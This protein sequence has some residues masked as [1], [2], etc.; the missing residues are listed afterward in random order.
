ML[1][2]AVALLVA[3]GQ[4]SQA[5]TGELRV[6]VTDA[7]GG[8]LPGPVEVVSQGNEIR[9]QIDTD[10]NGLAIVRRLPFGSYRVIVSRSGFADAAQVV[11]V[12]SALPTDFHVTMNVSAVQTQTTVTADSTLLDPH[13]PT[14]V[15]RIGSD[16]LQRRTTALPGRVVPDLVNTQPGWLLEANGILH[17]RGSE[18][19]TQYVVDG[20]P[21]TDNRSPVFAPES[22]ADDIHSMSIMTGGYPAEY[23]RKLGGVI[24]VVTAS[25]ARRGFGSS[26]STS[27][28]SF[29]TGSGDAIVEHGGEKSTISVTAAA[30]TTDR[31][32]DPPVADNFTNQASTASASMRFE[33]NVSPSSRV[34]VILRHAS[35]RFL[36]PNENIQ[37][38]AGQRQ[39]RNGRENAAQFSIQRIFSSSMVGDIRGMV[40]DVSAKLWSNPQSTPIA[41]SQDRGFRE[42]YLN[43][44]MSG[45]RGVHEW[46]VGADM[47]AGTARE[48]FSYTITDVNEFDSDVPTAFAFDD[49]RP[50]REQALF[51][52][53]QIRSGRWTVNVGLRWDHYSLVVEDNALSPRLAVAWSAGPDLVFRASYDRVFQTPAIENLLLASTDEFERLGAEGARLPVPTSRGNFFEAGVSKALGG[54]VRIDVAGYDRRISDMADDDLLLNTG[55]SFPIAFRYGRVYGAE[56]KLD[57]RQWKNLSASLG[58]SLMR[59]IGELPVTGGLFLGDDTEGLDST[60]DF[61][62]T[63]DQRHT[64]RARATYQVSPSAWV[65]AVGSYGSGLPFEDFEGTPEEAAEQFGRDVLD[66]V[67]F[68]TGRVRPNASLDIASGVTIAKS[69]KHVVRLQAEVRNLTNRFDVINFAGLFSGTALAAPRSVAIRVRYD[70]R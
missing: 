59:G 31:Y 39:D 10:A 26:V 52:Q 40:R 34:G 63:Q 28:G 57:L 67:N 4:F 65:A 14:L 55:V 64:I 5:N 66:R 8:A 24:E 33:G 69:A 30:A 2:C 17:P 16:T 47:S 38:E 44:S 22:G 53:D 68:E 56:T 11:E 49:R 70:F 51:V 6:T 25:S 60:E 9:Q 50:D 61:P 29:D 18:Y 3:V 41:A 13:Q 45:H 32:L 20:L 12:R 21:M 35:S 19:Q 27:V 62:L 7:T 58:Y 54:R 46:K 42:V 43:G 36:V 1:A 37:Q 48:E 15:H 23:G